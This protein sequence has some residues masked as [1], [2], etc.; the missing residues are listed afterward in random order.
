MFFKRNALN[1][2]ASGAAN[3]AV[4]SATK[5]YVSVLSKALAYELQ[6]TG[7]RV[8]CA[9]PGAVDSGFARCSGTADAVCFNVP[10]FH[11][12]PEAVVPDI[13]DAMYVLAYTHIWSYYL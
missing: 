2:A 8:T 11:H 9:Y 12:T 5:A 10:F 4:Y 13:I 6:G 1:I 7:V 3:T